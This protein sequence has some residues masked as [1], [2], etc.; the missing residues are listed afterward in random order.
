MKANITLSIITIGFS[1]FFLYHA[2]QIPSSANAQIGSSGWP[3]IILTFTLAMGILQL[4]IA[5]V[6]KDD[7][8][9][10]EDADAEEGLLIKYRHFYIL[11]SIAIYLVLLPV[12]GFVVV[13]P[14]LFIFLVWLLGM[15]KI[16]DIVLVSLIGNT[17]FFGIFIFLLSIPFPR[18]IGF[19]RSFSLLIY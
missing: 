19:F 2:F 11:L 17:I 12:V 16:K 18:G 3:I 1:I 6:K 8:A 14:I 15:R 10:I 13:T 9:Q 7:E 5:L 4:V